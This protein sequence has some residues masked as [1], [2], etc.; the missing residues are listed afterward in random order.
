M[1]EWRVVKDIPVGLLQAELQ[2]LTTEGFEI[3]QINH[4][5]PFFEKVSYKSP[6][7]RLEVFHVIA[8][9]V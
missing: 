6:V 5:Q 9:K 1:V 8:F 7:K 4:V 2:L 3:Y